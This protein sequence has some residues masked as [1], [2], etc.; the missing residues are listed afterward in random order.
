MAVD[1]CSIGAV[2][3]QKN[4]IFILDDL[5]LRSRDGFEQFFPNI[6][7][8][9]LKV[10]VGSSKLE[11]FSLQRNSG[12]CSAVREELTPD[13]PLFLLLLLSKDFLNNFFLLN[14]GL[15]T[16]GEIIMEIFYLLM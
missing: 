5:A 8:L 1:E 2:I 13:T 3:L 16:C 7:L 14:L 9:D 15:I 10:P 11:A 6:G 12:E 4:P